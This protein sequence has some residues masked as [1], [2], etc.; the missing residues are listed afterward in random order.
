MRESRF[1]EFKEDISNS[2]LKTVSA[3][4]NYDGG[5]ILFGV[6]DN[7]EVTG[8]KNPITECLNIENKINDS[9]KPRIDFQLEVNKQTNVITLTVMEGINKPYFYKSKAYKRNDSST[10]EVEHYEL[11]RLILE[12]EDRNYESLLAQNQDLSFQYLEESLITHMDIK[13]LSQDV[14]ITLELF[15]KEEGF[16]QAAELLAD[17]NNFYGIDII[18]FG[19]TI[20]IILDR[21]TFS[22]ISIL[23]QF[24]KSLTIYRKYYQYE[25][26]QGELRKK[27]E[28]IPEEAF[29]E[30]IANALI[31]RE[32]DIT[33]H[34]RV[35]M[36]EDLIEISSPGGLP[37]GITKEEYL[38][39]QIPILRNPIIG[40]IFFRLHH[41]ERFGTGIKRIN[42][43]Y[44]SSRVKPRFKIYENS[45]S[46]ILPT[47]KEQVDLSPDEKL[48]YESF[49]GSKKLS[50]SEVVKL[51]GFGKTKALQL[52]KSL[53]DQGLLKVEGRGR[54]TKYT[55]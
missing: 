10:V 25:E 26:I 45:I 49:L 39:G 9:I 14:L 43:A 17:K 22:G 4:S 32:W 6:R 33:S 42:Q 28:I 55:L 41:I 11:K 31:H 7:G 3:F 23:E 5:K 13:E 35:S 36:N 51:T 1:L 21:E 18:R 54:G 8:M 48:V 16:N 12:G 19:E 27:L 29:R 46:V 53:V 44:S 30:A 50:S 15:K 52:L 37:K 47:M 40:N 34:I 20:N 38:D 24:E 2:F